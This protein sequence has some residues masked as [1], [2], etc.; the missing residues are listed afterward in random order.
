[1]RLL[2]AL[3]VSLFPLAALAQPGGGVPTGSVSGSTVTSSGLTLPLTNWVNRGNIFNPVTDHAAPTDGVTDATTALLASLT[4]CTNAGG[5]TVTWGPYRLA[6]LT[7]STQF[8]VSPGCNI[9][10]SYAPSYSTTVDYSAVVPAL[11]MVPSSK[12][13]LD[14]HASMSGALI[15]ASTLTVPTTTRQAVNMISG[16]SGTALQLNGRYVDV[17]N[18]QIL[19]FA[20]PISAISRSNVYMRNVFTDGT[21]GPAMS[22]CND[23]CVWDT[24]EAWPYLTASQSWTQI[25]TTLTGSPTNDGGLIQLPVADT[26]SFVTGDTLFV[27]GVGGYTGANSKWAVTVIDST[28]LDLQS[29]QSTPTATA[30]LTSGSNV[31]VLTSPNISIGVG[32]TVTDTTTGGN[33]SGGTTV[34]FRSGPYVY[35]SAPAA[36]TGATDSLSFANGAYTSGGT[37]Y[38][39]TNYRSGIG[40]T[41]TSNDGLWCYM[42][43]PDEYSVGFQLTNEVTDNFFG[44]LVD[45]N[46]VLNDPTSIGIEL[47]GTT[48]GTSWYGGYIVT[49]GQPIIVNETGNYSNTLS[50]PRIGSGPSGTA[51]IAVLAGRAQFLGSFTQNVGGVS[52]PIFALNAITKAQYTGND[53]TNATWYYQ[54]A[55]A[56]A[57]S[58][59]DLTSSGASNQPAALNTGQTFTGSTHFA[60]NQLH[61][62]GA[63]SG[64]TTLISTATASGTVTIPAVTD[65]LAVLGTG[66]T[67]TANQHFANGTFFL[68]GS[69]GSLNLKPQSSASGTLTF[70]NATDTVAILGSQTFSGTQFFTTMGTASNCSSGASPAVCGSAAAGSAAV[71]TGAS[72]TL[73]INTTA[74]TANSQIFVNDDESLGAKLGVTCNTSIATLTNP[75]VTARSAAA[76]FTVQINATIAVNPACI[77]WLIVN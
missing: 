8:H 21:N 63:T 45:G 24:V 18:V 10:N 75:V 71:P 37:V 56:Q 39:D 32:Q 59:V 54:G 44:S 9:A 23:V 20:N 3:F 77:S 1:M 11:V 7:P 67:F 70:P 36:G 47:L 17:E 13:Y 16:F 29:S 76:S 35:L 14:G 57:N 60:N 55:A 6:L 50:I 66:Q 30:A 51:T 49:A 19:G 12:I 68:N 48:A 52:P 53:F 72:P 65:T 33:V 58:Y 2:L 74:V 34:V 62:N 26:S 27:T 40:F 22:G 41:L 46:P 38:L 43:Y 25:N 31:V 61:L 64:N 42:C 5:G 28:H 15:Y 69:S 73:Q 4:D